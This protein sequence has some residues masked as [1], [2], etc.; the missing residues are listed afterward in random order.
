M[1]RITEKYGYY[2]EL[3]PKPIKGDW[4]GSGMHT[5]FSNEA[6]RTGGSEELFNSY[7][8]KL[9]EVHE[10]G[11][12]SYGSDNDMRLTGLHETQSIDKFSYG[13]SDRGASIR[14]FFVQQKP[15]LK[16]HPLNR[17]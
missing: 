6:M 12:A 4:N 15:L 13:V 3:H 16:L 7:C 10:E 5:N 8:D 11:I 2:I 1:N 17:N 9:G 14:E